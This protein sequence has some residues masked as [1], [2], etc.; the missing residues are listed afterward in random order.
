MAWPGPGHTS[1]S[2]RWLRGVT[3]VPR[4]ST[5]VPRL[6]VG[7][8]DTGTAV[9]PGKA[10]SPWQATLPPTN[11]WAQ[12]GGRCLFSGGVPSLFQPP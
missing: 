5:V 6:G 12:L 7:H 1:L 9:L 2:P 11:I 8:E 3:G 10:S 4:S